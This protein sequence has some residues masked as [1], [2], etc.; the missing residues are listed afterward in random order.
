[1]A[2]RNGNPNLDRDRGC[3]ACLCW[4]P[5]LAEDS[6]PDAR[7]VPAHRY[8]KYGPAGVGNSSEGDGD[9]DDTRS[10]G[11]AREVRSQPPAAAEDDTK[12]ALSC[13]ERGKLA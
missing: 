7:G 9:P 12:Y 8:P 6:Q 1:M 11:C 4:L 13:R 2:R 3:A 5:L 10:E